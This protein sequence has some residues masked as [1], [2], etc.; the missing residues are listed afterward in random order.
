R[1]FAKHEPGFMKRHSLLAAPFLVAIFGCTPSPKNLPGENLGAPE[2]T[3]SEKNEKQRFGHMAAQVTPQM[4]ALFEKYDS[5]FGGNFNCQTCHG[6][7]AELVNWRMPNP[8]ISSLSKEN[9]LQE[10]LDYDAEMT[11]FM[12]AEVTPALKTL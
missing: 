2:I 11:N 9:T 8:E 12:M 4:K 1:A 5:S 10:S 6:K 3:W 7:N